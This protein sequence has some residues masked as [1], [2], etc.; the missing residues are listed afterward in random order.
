M[1]QGM[2]DAR[3]VT[4]ELDGTTIVLENC[5]AGIE[6]GIEGGDSGAYFGL[7]DAEALKVAHALIGMVMQRQTTG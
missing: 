1:I 2:G 4:I 3:K 7:S 6:L 5:R